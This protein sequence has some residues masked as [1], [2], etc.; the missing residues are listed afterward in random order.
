M[1]AGGADSE[2]NYYDICDDGENC[3]YRD[4]DDNNY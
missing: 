3:N 2:H 4:N 1:N